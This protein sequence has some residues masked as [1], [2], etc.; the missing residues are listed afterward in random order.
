MAFRRR[1]KS[2]PFFSQEFLIQNHADIVFSLVIFILIGLMFEATAK[3]AILFIQP[4]YNISTL[5]PDGKGLALTSGHVRCQGISAGQ[6]MP[7]RLLRNIGV[8][9][10]PASTEERRKTV[11]PTA[12]ETTPKTF[13]GWAHSYYTQGS[14]VQLS[15]Y[16]GH[17]HGYGLSIALGQVTDIVT[18]MDTAAAT[19]KV[20]DIVTNTASA[21]DSVM[22]M[23]LPLKPA[24]TGLQ[25]LN[26]HILNIPTSVHCLCL[27]VPPRV[28]QQRCRS[29]CQNL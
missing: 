28:S 5:S 21:M 20:M 22:G 29:H 11:P 3:T 9:Y 2:Y 10:V 1:N 17:N 7:F 27:S 6:K 4:Q 13:E 8:L 12:T 23:H 26:I 16:Y 24:V 19:A 15:G 14:P 18:N 25:W